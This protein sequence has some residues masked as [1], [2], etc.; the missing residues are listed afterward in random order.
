MCCNTSGD[1][2]PTFS[3][4]PFAMMKTS[5]SSSLAELQKWKSGSTACHWCHR[6]WTPSHGNTLMWRSRKRTTA[7]RSGQKRQQLQQM[8]QLQQL[9]LQSLDLSRIQLDLQRH[10]WDCWRVALTLHLLT[11]HVVI[12]DIR[13]SSDVHSGDHSRS[14]RNGASATFRSPDHPWS[15]SWCISIPLA[16]DLF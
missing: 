3:W 6:S 12:G 4:E 1:V 9:Q 14:T 7:L 8:Q 16:T 11:Q 2:L 15:I 10:C 13:T 5:K